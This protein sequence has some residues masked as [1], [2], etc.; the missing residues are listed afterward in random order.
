MQITNVT[1][2]K[3][4]F[5]LNKRH[6]STT[7]NWNWKIAFFLLKLIKW[8]EIKIWIRITIT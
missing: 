8:N 4:M 7:L 5:D 3:R 6:E 2:K 1:I